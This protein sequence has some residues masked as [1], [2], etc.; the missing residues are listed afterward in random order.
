MALDVAQRGTQRDVFIPRPCLS[1][2][3]EVPIL[4]HKK[5]LWR[6]AITGASRCTSPVWESHG[7][8]VAPSSRR[9]SACD[10]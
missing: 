9:P 3:E 4:T 6:M 7:H 1:S 10:H 5:W 2:L 8:N